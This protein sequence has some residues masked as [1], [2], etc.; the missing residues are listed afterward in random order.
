MPWFTTDVTRIVFCGP[1]MTVK[2]VAY[3]VPYSVIFPQIQIWL[4]EVSTAISSPATNGTPTAR[5]KGRK[6]V[7]I[8]DDR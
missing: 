7:L 5:D 1:A 6:A 2:V 3:R 8:P 4:V